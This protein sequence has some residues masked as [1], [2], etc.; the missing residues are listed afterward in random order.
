MRSV[1]F[2]RNTHL[3]LC[4][5]YR[6]F[7]NHNFCL[8]VCVFVIAKLAPHSVVAK[9]FSLKFFRK[10]PCITLSVSVLQNKI[11]YF[12]HSADYQRVT[13]S[14]CMYVDKCLNTIHLI[15]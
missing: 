9:F 2:F 5:R 1:I 11:G 13:L 12:F 14:P 10:P 6:F 7:C 8:F 3:R 4:E 15:I